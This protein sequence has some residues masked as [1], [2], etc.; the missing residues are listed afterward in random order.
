MLVFDAAVQLD[1]S[2]NGVFNLSRDLRLLGVVSYAPGAIR[3][4][5]EVREASDV[6]EALRAVA[7]RSLKRHR[8][9][10]ILIELL[11]INDGE[12]NISEFADALRSAFLA[13]GAGSKTWRNYARAFAMWFEY[14]HLVSMAKDGRICTSAPPGKKVA[15]LAGVQ[16]VRPDAS[17]PSGAPGPAITLLRRLRDPNVAPPAKASSLKRALRD[18]EFLGAIDTGRDGTVRLVDDQLLDALGM[19]NTARLRSLIERVPGG[20]ATLQRLIDDPA[21]NPQVVGRML[22]EAARA[23]W[24]PT[25]MVGAGK[26]FRGW[27][28]WAG[29]VT[30]TRRSNS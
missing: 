1:T 6:E 12:I 2:E 9:F 27:A 3:I 19:V 25:T 16:R 13:V 10:R 17:F 30:K 20:A 28:R 15:I 4:V 7:S 26:H 5:D 23:V 22:A 8:V 24:S 29:I 18:L 21:A 14:A 11:E